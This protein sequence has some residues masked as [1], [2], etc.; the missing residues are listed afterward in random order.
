LHRKLK[1]FEEGDIVMA[2][3][4]KDRFPRGMY[5]K[6]KYKKIGPCNI[7]RKIFDNAYKLDFSKAFEYF[8]IFNVFDLYEFHEGEEDGEVGT[9]QEWE[10]QFLVKPVEEI[11]EILTKRVSG[12]KKA[13]LGSI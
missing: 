12:K 6:L 9:M 11:E 5:N 2:H 10:G 7:L 8:P 1:V 13:R 3:L 4:R